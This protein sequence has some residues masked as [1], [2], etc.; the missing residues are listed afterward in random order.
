MATTPE[1][2]DMT[3]T[4]EVLSGVVHP[5]HVDTLGH[6]NARWYAHLLDDASFQFWAR[7]GLAQQQIRADYGVATVTASTKVDFLREMRAGDC[8]VVSGGATRVGGKSVTLEFSVMVLATG[9][10]HARFTTVEVFVDDETHQ[11]VTV[12]EIVLA[13]LQEV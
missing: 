6:M 5:W 7:L 11:S 4:R 9:A 8:Y 10:E 1:T 12:P 2:A 13:R 3:I